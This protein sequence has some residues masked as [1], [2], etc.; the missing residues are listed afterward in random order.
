[1]GNYHI[2]V[3]P[4]NIEKKYNNCRKIMPIIDEQH[5]NDNVYIFDSYQNKY[6]PMFNYDKSKISLYKS[7]K[8]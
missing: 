5:I 4:V 3:Y 8:N 7:N 2:K 1:M 6:I